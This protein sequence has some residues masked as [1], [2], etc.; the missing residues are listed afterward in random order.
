MT[1][2]TALVIDGDSEGAQ[3]ALAEL[4]R[5]LDRA[6]AAAEETGQEWVKASVGLDRLRAAQEEAA[7]A[8]VKL[9]AEQQLAAI[10]GRD[11]ALQQGAT[12]AAMQRATV[13]AGQQRAGMQQLSFQ[14]GDVATMFSMGARPMQIFASQGTQVVQAISMIRGES[15][16]LIGFLSGP[17]GAVMTGAVMILGSV[18]SAHLG[19]TDASE[20]HREAAEDLKNAIDQLHDSTV[21]SSQSTWASINADIAKANSLRL[22]TQEALRLLQVELERQKSTLEVA[23][24]VAARPI[25]VPGGSGAASFVAAGAER[26]I[27]TLSGAIDIVEGRIQKLDE[28]I[29][30]KSGERIQ[31]EVAASFDSAAA[32]A[33]KYDRALDDLNGRLGAGTITE[34]AYRA[35][36]ARITAQ[37]QTEEEQARRG[38][39]SQRS[40]AAALTEEEKARRQA[41]EETKRYI[42][43]LEDEI[44]KIGLDAAGLRQL[45]VAR[46]MEA[47]QTKD[48]RQR[49]ADL[50]QERERGLA[51]EAARQ[52]ASTI[53]NDNSALAG[54]I[55]G[56]EREAQVLG[57][58]GQERERALLRLEREAAIRPLLT[59]LAEAEAQGLDKIADGLREQIALLDRKYGLQIQ[60]G[61]E[62]ARIEAEQAAIDG[63]MDG[64]HQLGEAGVGALSAIALHGENAGDVIERLA[65]SIADA[66]LQAKLLN[67]GPLAGLFGGGGSGGPEN[68]LPAA[69]GGGGI[70]GAIGRFFGGGRA[71]GGPVSPR[72]F[73]AV[74]ENS[75]A[76]GL[77]F[78]L[79]PGRIEPPGN[80]NGDGGRTVIELHVGAG[81]LFNVEVASIAGDVAVQVVHDNAPAIV[82]VAAAETARLLT[83]PRM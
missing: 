16:G 45:E 61:D 28:T 72:Q 46:A 5:S 49:I 55:A 70:F 24:R 52:R 57:L 19:A 66:V 30:L 9:N 3:R 51:I 25:G 79:A 40:R 73:Y 47:A 64:Y 58:V 14:I 71:N 32:A 33:L 38:N 35:G 2:R 78:P 43:G 60:I 18:A 56:I 11:L 83:R 75:T 53:A 6:E 15:G 76:P 7:A 54:E 21:R 22:V 26:E 65:L 39:R 77:F 69:Y 4:D 36:L 13:S 42:A 59:Q 1:L 74:N 81:E 23:Q 48:Q 12:T 37:R 17:W 50:N 10:H 8:G 67:S 63:L 41:N 62:A 29:R 20:E 80:D 31:M 44:A 68:L 82:E 34:E 27:A